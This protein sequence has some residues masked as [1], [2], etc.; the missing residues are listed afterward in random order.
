VLD[1]DGEDGFVQLAEDRAIARE[2]DILDQ[3]LRD[4]AAALVEAKMQQVIE[5]GL[6]GAEEVQ[7]AVLV[8]GTVF[9]GNGCLLHRGRDLSQGH[10]VAPLGSLMDL[11]QKDGARPVVD[12]GR[13]REAG[14]T[15]IRGGGEAGPDVEHARQ[16]NQ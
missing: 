10:D 4:R 9:D 8:K 6:P 12:A 16:H 2:I 1:L 15:Q 5:A 11:G 14:G 7:A 3:L 13:E